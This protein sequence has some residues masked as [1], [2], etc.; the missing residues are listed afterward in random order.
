M[1]KIFQ[2][3]QDYIGSEGNSAPFLFKTDSN[4]R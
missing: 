4:L 1:E 2:N 3:E